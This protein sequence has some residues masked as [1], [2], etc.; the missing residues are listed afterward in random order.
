MEN[1]NIEDDNTIYEVIFF[2]DHT[3][4]DIAYKQYCAET[5]CNILGYT[6]P[7]AVKVVYEAATKNKTLVFSSRNIDK[8]IN[9][10]DQL[11]SLELSCQIC[12]LTAN[13][14]VR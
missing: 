14:M 2:W 8:A 1:N 5:L 10:R 7:L 11:N 6:A 3:R 13:S 4:K 9:L 12:P